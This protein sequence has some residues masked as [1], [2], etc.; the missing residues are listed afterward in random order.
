MKTL[1]TLITV[2][3]AAAFLTVAARAADL[4]GDWEWTSKSSSGPVHMT[5]TL[6]QKDGALTGTVTGR[7]GPAE[8]SDASIKGGVV[9]FTVVRGVAPNMVIFKYSGTIAGNSIT[10]SIERTTVGAPPYQ[11]DW[12]ATRAK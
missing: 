7:Q 1:R 3:F 6:V 4:S 9:V 2:C 11:M 12:K 8:I 5:A 10:G